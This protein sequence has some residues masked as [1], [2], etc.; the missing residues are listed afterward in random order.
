VIQVEEAFSELRG[1]HSYAIRYKDDD[2][3]VSSLLVRN[4]MS[5]DLKI[6]QRLPKFGPRT[7]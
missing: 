3:E 6:V 5:S 7:S 1:V 4:G 2:G